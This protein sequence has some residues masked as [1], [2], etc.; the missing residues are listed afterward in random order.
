MG[1]NDD[2]TGL[3]L[4]VDDSFHLEAPGRTEAVFYGLGADGTVSS[5]KAAIKI[6]GDTTDLW[7]QGHFV[8]DSKKSGSTTVSHLRFGPQLIRSTYEVR[9]AGFV[10]VHD[11]EALD[12]RD[13][14]EVAAPG[15][16]V[17]LNCPLPADQ[18]WDSLPRPAQQVLVDRGC[19]LWTIDA[20]G[21]AESKGLGRRINTVMSTCFFA[22]SGVLPRDEAIARVKD[23]VQ[24]TWGKRGPE[25]VRRNVEA[26]DATLAELHQVPLGAVT[27]TTR[28]AA[29]GACRRAPTSCS[30]SPAC[31]SRAMGTACP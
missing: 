6:I 8:Y 22:L 20:A 25:V 31:C 13:V 26:I 21:V 4:V 19:T 24:A 3:S 23:S 11:P 17:L 16:T 2:V 15:A 30:G 5:N 28:A 12:R 14:L 1:I 27:S 7:C 9:S 29:G 18:V 10:A